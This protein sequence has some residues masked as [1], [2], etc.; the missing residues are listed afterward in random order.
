[1]RRSEGPGG[2]RELAVEFIRQVRGMD[3]EQLHELILQQAGEELA[4]FFITYATELMQREPRRAAENGSSLLLIGYL[5]R[6][7]EDRPGRRAI[8]SDSPFLH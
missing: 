7:F 3:R 8:A 6:C 4:R 1:M 2:K 5:I